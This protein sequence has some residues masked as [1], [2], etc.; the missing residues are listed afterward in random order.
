MRYTIIGAGKGGHATAAHLMSQGN[1]VCLWNRP[2]NKIN[3]LKNNPVLSVT[4]KIE[5]EFELDL[6][7]DDME[8][9][10][11]FGELVSV[12]AVANAYEDIAT[13]MAP[14]LRDGQGIILNAGGIGGTLL[15]LQTFLASRYSPSISVGQTNTCLYGCKVPQPGISLIKSIKNEMQFSELATEGGEAIYPK[16]QL[17][18][19]Q[20]A[21]YT[22]PLL[23]GLYSIPSM[24]TIG[25]VLNEERIRRKEDFRFY[26]EGVTPEIGR[27]MENMDA[28]RTAVIAALGLPVETINEW[29]HNK[30]GI[31]MGD[32]VDMLH[33]NPSYQHNAPAPKT[34]QHRYFTEEVPTKLVIQMEMARALG[35]PQPLTEHITSEASRL[36]GRDLT[37]EARTLDS[38]GLT[39]CDIQ[40]YS[41]Q[42][43]HPYLERHGLHIPQL[44]KG[45][46]RVA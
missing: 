46:K 23:P 30:Y 5:G 6:V 16:A 7:T 43:I 17:S 34:F 29:I 20:L 1:E 42:G 18:F 9:A 12:M 8:E 35:I 39:P 45:T 2:G 27:F 4:G 10:L 13:Q 32:L 15:F 14:H 44:Q 37:L 36:V 22:D 25:M 40:N 41:E 21:L 38:L 33:A 28:E 26:V 11:G 31:P 19:P 24:H 3:R